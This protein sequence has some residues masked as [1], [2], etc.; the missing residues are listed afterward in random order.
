MRQEEERVILAAF[1]ISELFLSGKT[2]QNEVD[3]SWNL[4]GGGTMP[5]VSISGVESRQQR[6]YY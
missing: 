4:C 3:K 1:L 2:A 5:T 6:K